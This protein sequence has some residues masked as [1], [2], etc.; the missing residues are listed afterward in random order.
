[1]SPPC[2]LGESEEADGKIWALVGQDCWQGASGI[3]LSREGGCKQELEI[4]ALA[5]SHREIM[6]PELSSHHMWDN[7]RAQKKGK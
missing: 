6:K 2:L 3:G 5:S 4:A 7:K 1:M